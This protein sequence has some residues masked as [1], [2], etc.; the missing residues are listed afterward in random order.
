[1]AGIDHLMINA[2]HY[3]LSVQFYA[4][5]MPLIGYPSKQEYPGDDPVTGFS[6]PSGRSSRAIEA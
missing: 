6:G 4:W 2:N 5:L 1:M 3:E